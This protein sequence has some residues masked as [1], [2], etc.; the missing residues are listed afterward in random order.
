MICQGA[1]A[2]S[3]AA[4]R[5]GSTPDRART[6]LAS[7]AERMVSR[8]PE[9]ALDRI[10]STPRRIPAAVVVDTWNLRGQCFD[11]LGERRYPNVE[12][13]KKALDSYGFEVTNVFAALAVDTGP[14]PSTRIKECLKTSKVYVD[15]IEAAPD[16]TMLRGRLVERDGA[17]EE[18]L[19]D[20]LCALRVFRCAT[21]IA[22]GDSKA[23]AIVVLSEDVDLSPAYELAAEYGV[24]V[25]AASNETVYSRRGPWLIL[26]DSAYLNMCGRSLGSEQGHERRLALVN[27]LLTPT[28]SRSFAVRYRETGSGQVV[29]RHRTGVEGVV[30]ASSLRAAVLPGQR[31]TLYPV[32][33]DLGATWNAFPRLSLDVRA[34][35]VG[36]TLLEGTVDSWVEPTRVVVD[37]PTIGKKTL[38]FTPGTVVPP[39]KVL[40]ATAPGRRPY[41]IGSVEKLQDRLNWRDPTRPRSV[42]VTRSGRSAGSLVSAELGN[43]LEVTLLP[44]RGD[45]ARPG[46]K[47][48]A[49]PIQADD[50]GEVTHLI[51]V[52]SALEATCN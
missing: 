49:V 31:F 23:E 42:T 36:A 2:C 45:V 11:V 17:L 41:L 1:K 24:P 33:I 50:D 32:G 37:V 48:A 51:A 12:G 20:V 27:Q 46:T 10:R 16:A 21:E 8:M 25:Y 40:I 3:D 14:H 35:A 22:N 26:G 6:G 29:L 13:I 38:G 5:R 9:P 34:S 39:M 47:Y 30:Q 44:P 28:E 7:V 43:G 19:V 18:K 52:S 15:R 4:R